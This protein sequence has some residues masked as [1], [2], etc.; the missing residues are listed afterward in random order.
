LEYLKI[1][2]FQSYCECMIQL[3]K[4]KKALAFAPE[5]SYEYW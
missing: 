3:G 2:E 5:V 4:W 1:G